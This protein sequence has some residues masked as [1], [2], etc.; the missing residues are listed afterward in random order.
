M[1][2][3][4]GHHDHFIP[5]AFHVGRGKTKTRNLIMFLYKKVNRF[6]LEITHLHSDK[7]TVQGILSINNT[8]MLT[9]MVTGKKLDVFHGLNGKD[10]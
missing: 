9:D 5:H 2:R 1:G 4:D 3:T 6:K 7:I 10:I 8:K